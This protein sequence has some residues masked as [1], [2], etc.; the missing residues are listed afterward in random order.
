MTTDLESGDPAAPPEAGG[1]PASPAEAGGEVAAP[2]EAGF[3]PK[4]LTDGKAPG[5][6]QSRYAATPWK[7]IGVEGGYLAVLL[8]A[9]VAALIV[10]WLRLPAVWWQ[11]SPV[12]SATFTRYGYAWLAG[13]LGGVL[14]AMKW[15]YHSVAKGKVAHRSSTVA[16][17]DSSHFRRFG[18]FDGGDFELAPRYRGGFCDVWYQGG[19]NWVLGRVFLR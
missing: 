3:A 2:S 7:W 11:L 4:D 8:L 14:F 9:V 5:E 19:R 12:Q 15:L 10:L 18:F 16:I 6:W 17:P 13:T 1:T